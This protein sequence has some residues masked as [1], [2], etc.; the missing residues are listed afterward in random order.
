MKRIFLSLFAVAALSVSAQQINPITQAT[1]NAYAEL[2]SE[3]PKDYETYYDRAA[4]YYQLGMYDDALDDITK[5][6]RFSPSKDKDV[7]SKDYTLLTNILVE[8]GEYGKALE[9]VDA[10]LSF[11]PNNYALLYQKG[12]ICLHLDAL[13]GARNAFNAMQRMQ[14]RSQE[15]LIGL[16]RVDIMEKK[17]E[18]AHEKIKA[19]DELNSSSAIT[20]SRIGDLFREMGDNNEAARRYLTAFALADTNDIRPMSSLLDLARTD[21][22]AVQNALDFGISRTPKTLPLYFLKGNIAFETG[23]YLDAVDAFTSLLAKEDGQQAPVYDRMAQTLLALNRTAEAIPFSDKAVSME[24]DSYNKLTRARAAHA[25]GDNA[26]A[27]SLAKEVEAENKLAIDALVLAAEA[28]MDMNNFREAVN[29]LNEAVM[30]DGSQLYPL[31][32]RAWIYK[33]KLN[34][35]AKAQAD[36][37]RAAASNNSDIKSLAMKAMAQTAIDRQLDSSMTLADAA[38]HAVSP[39]DFYWMAVG[40]SQSGNPERAKEMLA[41]AR[42]LGYQNIYNLDKNNTANLNIAPIR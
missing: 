40:Y 38:K 24:P 25:N 6:I 7:K 12:N 27:L 31:M 20:Y 33:N 9:S 41:K 4:Q 36:Y 5:A 10:A 35:S 11:T 13:K 18:D 19:A 28:N 30:L 34:D 2:L 22:A 26:K 3:N 16:A 15:A 23:H 8:K 1:L 29:N 39:E 37:K 17:Y 32:M 21:Y 42:Q 14:P